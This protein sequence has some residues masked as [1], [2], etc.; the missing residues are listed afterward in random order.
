MRNEAY[1]TIRCS[2]E[3]WSA[4]QDTDFLQTRSSYLQELQEP[5]LQEEQPADEEPANGLFTPLIPKAESFFIRSFEEQ[6]GQH[7]C[8]FPNT[9]TSK[10]RPH[11]LH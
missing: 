4:P 7:T 11:P 3:C 5:L 10:S 1:L 8:L 2:D 6:F 9:S